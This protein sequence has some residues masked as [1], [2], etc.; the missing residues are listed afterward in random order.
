M[1]GAFRYS[2]SGQ[3]DRAAGQKSIA[4]HLA[5]HTGFTRSW[6]VVLLGAIPWAAVEAK[7]H[8]EAQA[9]AWEFLRGS[10]PLQGYRGQI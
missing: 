1:A 3:A 2:G 4:L 7:E 9:M 8:A 10:W 5:D 6:Q